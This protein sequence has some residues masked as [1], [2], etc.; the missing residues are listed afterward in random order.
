M[1]H[2]HT[3]SEDR[4]TYYMEQLCTIGICAMLGGVAVIL[5]Y[6]NIL[7]FILADKLHVWVL[8][9]GVALLVMAALRAI[10]LWWSVGPS[11][12][13]HTHEHG[14]CHEHDHHHEHAHGAVH[15]EHE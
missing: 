10:G 15:H 5:Y 1:G 9:S 7:R 12:A 14:H 2:T 8:G 3:H 6:Q 11:T 13:N 4:T